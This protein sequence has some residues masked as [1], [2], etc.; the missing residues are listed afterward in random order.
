M[1]PE[2]RHKKYAKTQKDG[3]KT[4]KANGGMAA[5]FPHKN[6]PNAEGTFQ[7]LALKTE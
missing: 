7:H 1:W 2:K 4:Q 6:G 5:F 3:K